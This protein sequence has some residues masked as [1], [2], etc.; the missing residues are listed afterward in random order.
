ML[1]V[2]VVY[3]SLCVLS[4]IKKHTQ[5]S[6]C[7]YEPVNLTFGL[8][9]THHWCHSSHPRLHRR[10]PMTNTLK[11]TQVLFLHAKSISIYKVLHYAAEPVIEQ[12]PGLISKS[13]ERLLHI[14]ASAAT[15]ACGDMNNNSIC[16]C[17]SRATAQSPAN[18]AQKHQWFC[19]T[20]WFCFD[21]LAYCVKFV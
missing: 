4:S 2:M 18:G 10:E 19:L 8:T 15:K 12:L 20:A 16:Y 9:K 6:L 3:V 14:M 5:A 11:L 7:F 1:Y 21:C 17:R 13:S